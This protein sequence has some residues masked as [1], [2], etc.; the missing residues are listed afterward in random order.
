M[1]TSR[2]KIQ[3]AGQ[4]NDRRFYTVKIILFVIYGKYRKFPRFPCPKSRIGW[5]GRLSFC[6]SLFRL[7]IYDL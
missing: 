6:P 7:N 2:S 1:N 4:M 3:S 5:G